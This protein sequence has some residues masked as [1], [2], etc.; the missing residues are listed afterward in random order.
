MVGGSRAGRRRRRSGSAFL[1]QAD[2]SP[3]AFQPALDLAA[4]HRKRTRRH[5]GWQV[6]GV[7]FHRPARDSAASLLA[8]RRRRRPCATGRAGN[9]SRP[10][11]DAGWKTVDW[12]PDCRGPAGGH[13]FDRSA[14]AIGNATRADAGRL[15]SHGPR[16]VAGRPPAGLPG[17]RSRQRA[18]G[19]LRFE[20]AERRTA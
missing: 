13:R 19:H 2:R 4:G 10:G 1:A 12:H 20:P 14:H 18:P 3:R 11:L 8:G 9:V 5:R 17:L 15:R 6:G 16:L 7:P